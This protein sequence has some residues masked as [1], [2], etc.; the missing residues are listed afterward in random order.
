VDVVSKIPVSRVHHRGHRD[1]EKTLQPNYSVTSVTF[2]VVENPLLLFN[3]ARRLLH[4]LREL[5][6]VIVEPT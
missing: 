3:L 1:T 2:S 6:L 4:T 5:L